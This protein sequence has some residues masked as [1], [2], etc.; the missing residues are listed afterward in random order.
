MNNSLNQLVI[1]IKGAGEMAT[2]VAY[3]LY[4]SG[5]KRIV[6]L[7]TPNPKAVRRL[8]AFSEVVY[9]DKQ[10][11]ESVQAVKTDTMESV[12]KAWEQ[13]RIA[14]IVDPQWQTIKRVQPDVVIDA[15]LAKS[16]TG[17]QKNE[18]PLVIAL[19]PG[20]KAG[21]DAHCV[22]E[23]NRGHNLG[24]VILEGSAEDYTGIPGIINGETIK[25]VLRAPADGN[26]KAVKT[27][28][29]MVDTGDLIGEV[30]GYA[31]KAELK[32]ILRGLIRDN[33]QIRK[34]Q[35][36]G[37]IDPRAEIAYCS[38]VSEKAR[39]IGGGVLEAILMKCNS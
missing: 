4:K 18:A 37:D 3:R 19:G 30:D 32:G 38:T 23:T 8:V 12:Y 5:F 17:T 36:L 20:Y 14:V 31:I 33:G 34:G 10:T 11:V 26:F 15:I 27:I 25:R 28:G 7:E 29:D 24:R 13:H 21:I 1:C 9:L 6:M 16:N 2:G 22:I 35:K 39:A